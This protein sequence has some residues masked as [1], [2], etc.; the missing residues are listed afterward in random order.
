MMAFAWL[1]W[2]SL[3]ILAVLAILTATKK[4]RPD[5]RPMMVEWAAPGLERQGSGYSVSRVTV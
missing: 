4:V 3:T 1:G 5:P 2:I